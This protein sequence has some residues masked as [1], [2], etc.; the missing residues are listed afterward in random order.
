MTELCWLWLLRAVL[1]VVTCR[2]HWTRAVS[3]AL[4]A[5]L[6]L[7]TLQHAAHWLMLIKLWDH[8]LFTQ[9][10][11]VTILPRYLWHVS[12]CPSLQS[13]SSRCLRRARARPRCW[14][15]WTRPPSPP[16]AR[17]SSTGCGWPP[18]SGRGSA[19]TGSRVWQTVISDEPVQTLIKLTF[20]QKKC[21]SPTTTTVW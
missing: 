14:R 4:R 6:Q 7:C 2:G 12:R 20:V 17:A 5:V 16:P 8:T 10:N 21:Y 9:H 1:H 15:P 11:T 18:A 3:S 13:P 19:W